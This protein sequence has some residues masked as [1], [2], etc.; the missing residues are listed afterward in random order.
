MYHDALGLWR[1]KMEL[2]LV[3]VTCSS[4]DEA[5][6]IAEAAIVEKL[7]ACSN[8]I[9]AMISTYMWQGK[10]THS[11]EVLLLLKTKTALFEKLRTRI[12]TLHS[13]ETPAIV[14]LPI[15][16]VDDDYLKWLESGV[17]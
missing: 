13:Y 4:V 8:V 7:A 6:T 2:S 10:L 9:P 5:Q 11:E 12:R 14:A 1:G 3:Y 16:A 17:E 15:A